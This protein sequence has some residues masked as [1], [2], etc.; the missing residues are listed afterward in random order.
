M[1]ELR[2]CR[3]TVPS[4][5]GPIDILNI[6]ELT[7]EAGEQVVIHGPSGTGKTTLFNVIAGLRP[8][9]AGEVNVAG[10]AL[11]RLTE[12]E[13]DR[14]RAT[15][16]GFIFQ[17]FNLLPSLTVLENVLLGAA[18]AHQSPDPHKARQLLRLVGL[19]ARADFFPGRLSVGEQQR[20]AVVRSLMHAPPLLMADEPTAALDQARAVEIV[21]L[22]RQLAAEQHCTLLVISHDERLIPQFPRSIPIHSI[23]LALSHAEPARPS[24]TGESPWACSN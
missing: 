9:T 13:R 2:S 7:I 3:V 12:A 19:E 1:V 22:L 4:P 11:H 10:Q 5:Q 6:P 8:I 15:Y 24:A 20:V 23:N 21:G 16:V 17:T 18:L 14:F